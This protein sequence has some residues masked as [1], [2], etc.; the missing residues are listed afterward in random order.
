MGRGGARLQAGLRL[1]KLSRVVKSTIGLYA[2]AVPGMHRA[3]LGERGGGS[4]GRRAVTT[5]EWAAIGKSP[6]TGRG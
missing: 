5:A 3:G 2:R 4:Y 1:D 6:W